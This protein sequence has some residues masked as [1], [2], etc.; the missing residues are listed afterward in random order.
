MV[1]ILAPSLR[2]RRTGAA[3]GRSALPR[4]LAARCGFFSLAGLSLV[5]PGPGEAGNPEPSPEAVE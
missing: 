2:L 3:G 5:I 4:A 1:Q